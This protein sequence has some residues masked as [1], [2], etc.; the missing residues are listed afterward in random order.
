MR[1]KLAGLG[2]LL[3]T[4]AMAVTDIAMTDP[5]LLTL[6]WTGSGATR[7]ASGADGA[8]YFTFEGTQLQATFAGSRPFHVIVD[9]G[10]AIA[11]NPLS[12][13]TP[14]VTNVVSGLASGNHTVYAWGS[15]NDTVVAAGSAFLTDGSGSVANAAF[16]TVY[17]TGSAPFSSYGKVTDCPWGTGTSGYGS[18]PFAYDAALGA[19]SAEAGVRYYAT[20]A[21]Q[22]VYVYGPPGTA[23]ALYSDGVQ[24]GSATAIA[25]GGQF[26]LLTVTGL[27]AG[28]HLYEWTGYGIAGGAQGVVAVMPSGALTPVS[29]PSRACVGI[30]GDSIVAESAVSGDSRLAWWAATHATGFDIARAGEGGQKVNSF[31]RDNTVAVTAGSWQ[32]ASIVILE[33][34][35]NDQQAYTG[36]GDIAA[37]QAAVQAELTNMA[38]GLPAGAK[39]L[40]EQILPNAAAHSDERD[41]YNAAIRAAVGTYSAGAPRIPV[42]TYST[43]GWI[44]AAA[45]TIGDALHPALQNAAAGG[46]PFGNPLRGY[47]KISNRLSFILAGYGAAGASFEVSGP[48][49]GTVQSAS[50]PFAVTAGAANAQ[51]SGETITMD[52]GG[53]G[54]AF[55]V[56]TGDTGTGSVVVHTEPGSTGFTFTYRPAESGSRSIHYSGLPDCWTAPGPT[57]YDAIGNTASGF[58]IGAKAH[59]P[60][61]WAEL[62]RR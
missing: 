62:W 9:G 32:T 60:D 18:W 46:Y 5:N 12:S 22:S 45:D 58:L 25:G 51:F 28:Q 55:V 57:V 36:T 42:C 47:G 39:M 2:L 44:D 38:A 53:S 10:A 43:D 49:T 16:G 7:V 19:P 56:S 37:F 35:V 6:G 13:S 29:A 41:A 31:L 40:E 8:I 24:V 1:I 59:D 21:A 20:G 52:D 17:A 50:S 30:Y 33:G 48:A 23:Y 15:Q 54:G 27:D 26:Q 3:A 61:V 14:T 11:V 34:G 4:R